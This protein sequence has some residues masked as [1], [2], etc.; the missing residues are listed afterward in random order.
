MNKDNGGRKIQSS[1]PNEFRS[2]DNKNHISQPFRNEYNRNEN[3]QK[4]Q[5][6]GLKNSFQNKQRWCNG[7]SYLKDQN[8]NDGKQ[9]FFNNQTQRDIDQKLQEQPPKKE[10][11][12][13]IAHEAAQSK[14]TYSYNSSKSG[15]GI[16]NASHKKSEA[17]VKQS[18]T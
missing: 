9:Q 14:K 1:K 8:H 7:E 18:S 2:Y 15:K 4:D 10:R 11:V 16:S 17:A 13:G 3:S 6:N 12:Y 5:L